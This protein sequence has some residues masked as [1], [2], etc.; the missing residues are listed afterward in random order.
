MISPCSS[1]PQL[2]ECVEMHWQWLHQFPPCQTP[3]SFHPCVPHPRGNSKGTGKTINEASSLSSQNLPPWIFPSR[4]IQK[5]AFAQM[6]LIR[7]AIL[8]KSSFISFFLKVSVFIFHSF[9]TLCSMA[10][11]RTCFHTV[12]A[13]QSLLH[14]S[15]VF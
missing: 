4:R 6:S 10:Y 3:M 14:S 11:E 2:I 15:V 9:K 7:C 8:P 13:P 12:D 1:I 5:P